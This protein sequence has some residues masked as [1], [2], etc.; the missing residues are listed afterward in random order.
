MI[1]TNNPNKTNITNKPNNPNKIKVWDFLGSNDL[2]KIRGFLFIHEKATLKTLCTGLGLDENE[3]S[4]DKLRIAI[5]RSKGQVTESK[6]KIGN[7]KIYVLSQPARNYL[8][9]QIDFSEEKRQREEQVK[10][11]TEAKIEAERTLWEELRTALSK[12]NYI[13][14][15]KDDVAIIDLQKLST[16]ELALFNKLQK[17]P[18]LFIGNAREMLSSFFNSKDFGITFSGLEAIPRTK[19]ERLRAKNLDE[20]ICIDV[21][22][23]ARSGIKPQ[24]I[25]ATFE[26]PTCGARLSV[27]QV[28]EDFT[29][30]FR[31]S[32]GRRGQFSLFSKEFIDV[33][34]FQADDLSIVSPI[35]NSL[36]GSFTSPLTKVEPLNRLTP[37]KDVRVF[38]KLIE[39]QKKNSNGKKSTISNMSLETYAVEEL[40][41]D[42]DIADF[43]EAEIKKFKSIQDK[44]NE[45]GIELIVSSFAP[46]IEGYQKI[47]EA[48]CIQSAQPRNS[49]KS[50]TRS[51]S[52]LLL[53]GDPGT[54]KSRLIEFSA[55][56]NPNSKLG[57]CGSASS[58]GI[59]ASVDKDP[60]LGWVCKPGLVLLARDLCALDEFNLLS[61]E[62]KQKLQQCFNE[63]RLT[64]NKADVHA[65]FDVTCGFL[66]SAN[67]THGVFNPLLP[68][69]NQFNI[70]PPILNRIDLVFSIQDRPN[71]EKDTQIATRMQLRE[72]GKIS[73]DHS[74]EELRD[75]FTYC[76]SL[77]EPSYNEQ[78]NQKIPEEYAELRTKKGEKP[79]INA[80]IVEALQRL[81]KGLARLRGS[82][83]CELKDLEGA[84]KLI[85]ESHNLGGSTL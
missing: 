18:S 80:R 26:C 58:V 5:S 57:S 19:V 63:R 3:K 1:K 29:E 83:V 15:I 75:F 44:I 35:R 69:E 48:L 85:K 33:G 81:S 61:E 60:T 51:K 17:E 27:L 82:S 65:V 50:P 54:A 55:S 56:I 20:T 64:I 72:Q 10:A 36:T 70:F 66:L 32:C 9:S 45:K 39:R 67:P 46:D 30:P 25:S 23:L 78:Y 34:T 49:L 41:P 76:R 28:T 84:L 7:E 62:D 79:Q 40:N 4:T 12:K 53:I 13:L 38:G 42:R 77:P 31:C 8:Q 68:V 24:V 2:D 14:S 47:K 59:T 43:S 37:G 22:I 21:K 74:T 16:L 11:E 71:R 6:E 52:N 73:Y